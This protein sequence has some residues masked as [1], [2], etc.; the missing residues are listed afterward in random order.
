LHR[1][2]I[3][4]F[5]IE[6]KDF[7]HKLHHSSRY[8]IL[9]PPCEAC[10]SFKGKL[11][12]AMKE[13]TELQQQVAY[14][15]ARLKK[16]ILSEKMIEDDLSRVKESATKSTYKLSI[17][18]ERCEDKG[19]KSAPRFI[20]SSTYHKVEETIKSTKTHYPSNPKPSFNLKRDVKK[21]T[22]KSKEDA[23]ICIFYC[24]VSHL[25]EFLL[26]V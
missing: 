11:F 8:T 2:D 3:E 23:L 20:P 7:N 6:I 13:N 17:G 18:F 26:S 16:I 10:V 22:P 5:V 4:D 9:S 24:S 21:E 25:D 19:K 1:S 14:L 12:Y 15:T